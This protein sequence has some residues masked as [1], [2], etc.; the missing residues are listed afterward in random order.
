MWHS[1]KNPHR[2]YSYL[3]IIWLLSTIISCSCK[4]PPTSLS[5]KQSGNTKEIKPTL[6][7]LVLSS[8]KTALEEDDLNFQ[9]ELKN[10]IEVEAK[11]LS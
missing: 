7:H 2:I 8:N 1:I 4:N 3:I 10:N 6:P 9:I 5:K 11:K